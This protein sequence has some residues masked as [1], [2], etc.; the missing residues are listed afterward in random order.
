MESVIEFIIGSFTSVFDL[1]NTFEFYGITLLE[2]L[3]ALMVIGV[4]LPIVLTFNRSVLGSSSN[5]MKAEVSKAR[6]EER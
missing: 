3:L 4:M 6:K 5:Y 1:F 2:Y